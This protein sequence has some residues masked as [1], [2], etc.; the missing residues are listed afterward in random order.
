MGCDLAWDA[1]QVHRFARA[2]WSEPVGGR[3]SS[4]ASATGF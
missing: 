1:K 3:V 2:V 4:V